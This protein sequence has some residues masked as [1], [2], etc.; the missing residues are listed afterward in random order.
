MKSLNPKRIWK[1]SIIMVLF[2]LAIPLV[3]SAGVAP[4]TVNINYY[5]NQIQ[6]ISY[7]VTGYDRIELDMSCPF[8][9]M[10]DDL[11]SSGRSHSFSVTITLP[12]KV[13]AD[14]GKLNCGFMIRE[15][16]NENLPPGVAA[17]VEVGVNIYIHVPYEGRYAKINLIAPNVNKGEPVYFQVHVT[18]LGEEDLNNLIAKIEVYDNEDNLRE[19]MFTT[20]GSAPIFGAT[21]LWKKME[22]VNYD[23]AKYKAKAT[24][25]YYGDEPVVD[26]KTFLIG[27]LF[28]NFLRFTENTSVGKINPVEVEVES[29]WGNLIENVYAEVELINESGSSGGSFKT[30]SVNLNPWTLEKLTGYWDATELSPGKYTAEITLNYGGEKTQATAYIDLLE[31]KVII[32]FWDSFKSFASTPAFIILVLIILITLN[33]TLWYLKSKKGKKNEKN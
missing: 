29:W 12:E 24:L 8:V 26:E 32:S 13:D 27:K 10:N 31:E 11:V 1:F 14:P 16:Q 4:S 15:K 21:D 25:N 7:E 20:S 19:T 17:R 9:K 18:N 5:P 28:V 2:L 22:T 3:L 33:M 23:A 30:I 6:T